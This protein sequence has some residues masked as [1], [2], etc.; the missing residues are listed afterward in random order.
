MSLATI[1]F[2]AIFLYM[3]ISLLL[4]LTAN[5][6]QY[7]QVVSGP[8]SKNQTYTGIAVRSETVIKTDT[9]GYV[10]YYAQDETKVRRSGMLF[11]IGADR[12]NVEITG[13]SDAAKRSVRDSIRSFVMHYDRLDYH[14]AA[15][16]TYDIS[17]KIVSDAPILSDEMREASF[18]AG[19][20]YTIG[21]ETITSAPRD[22]VVVYAVDGYET[23]D[24]SA[25][26]PEDFE[27]KNYRLT[28]LRTQERIEA[29]DPVCRLADSENWSLIIP[30]TALQIVRLDGIGNIRVKF[31]SDG[32]TQTAQL[33]IWQQ[34]DGN[35]YGKLDFT[36][37]MIRYVTDRFIDVELVTN[38]V[39]G[40][41]IP[42]TS[43]V[44]KEFFTVPEEYA[45]EGGEDGSEIGFV[46]E[47][48][49]SDGTTKNEFVTTT[50]YEHR[51]G[52]Y[53]IDNS[54]FSAGDVIVLRNSD[55]ERYIVR[56]TDTLEGVYCT[57]KGYA[58][59]RKILILDKN[60]EYCIV[61]SG[62]RYGIAQF[63]YIVLH[64]DE[65]REEQIIAQ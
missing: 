48:R 30:L 31:L 25:V 40:L 49:Q 45:T 52:K 62:T 51:D 4:Y 56:D 43:I 10:T 46:R 12:S 32:V 54:D 64:G 39:T 63:D 17:G 24:P 2:V 18:R 34:E 35:Y 38:T 58:V 14:D 27:K 13:M 33:S 23:F 19:G 6:V 55:G 11:G 37:G 5:H 20:T 44:S 60:E 57:N 29:G 59:F 26:T 50:L 3:A 42:I 61:E 8:L 41:K 53:Y 1:V 15:A 9:T 36:D 7:Y 28:S 21:N 65:V 16:L 47:V 22:G